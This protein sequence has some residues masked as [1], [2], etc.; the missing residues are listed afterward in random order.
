MIA[1][2][3]PYRLGTIRSIGENRS[4][5]VEAFEVLD[6]AA[7][8][9]IRQSATFFVASCAPSDD[10]SSFDCGISHRGGKAGFID[11]AGDQITV[12]GFA[13]NSFFNTRQSCA[14]SQGGTAFCRL[15]YWRCGSASGDDRVALE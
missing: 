12:P 7:R 15:C 1:D 8:E 2:F 6:D 13:G 14:K 3:A 11:V 10:G 4:R 9:L 5:E